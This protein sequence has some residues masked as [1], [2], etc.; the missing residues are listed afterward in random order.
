MRPNSEACHRNE[1]ARIPGEGDPGKSFLTQ[2]ETQEGGGLF[3]ASGCQGVR[4]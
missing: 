1:E 4:I 2:E 3:P